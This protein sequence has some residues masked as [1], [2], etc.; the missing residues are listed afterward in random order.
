M[1]KHIEIVN[2][3]DKILRGYLTIPS[4]FNGKLVIMYHGFTGNKTEHAGHFRNFSRILESKNI[5]S[6]RLDFSGNGESDGEF[7]DFTFDT[8]MDEANLI[9]D[10]AW[11]VEGVSEVCLLGFSMG[12]AVASLIAGARPNEVNKLLLWSPA[13][14]IIEIIKRYFERG[15]KLENGNTLHGDFEI[16]KEMISSL[17]KYDTFKGLNNYKNPVMIIHGSKD[18]AVNPLFSMRYA[19]SFDN[20]NVFKVEG[21]GHGYDSLEFKN[22]LYSKSLGFLK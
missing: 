2:K 11:K 10:F 1:I 18:L 20:S 15:I 4:N 13:G 5:A 7:K 3:F 22:I 12:G 8:L 6:L 9:L 16:S 17:D 21:A 14:N 19:V